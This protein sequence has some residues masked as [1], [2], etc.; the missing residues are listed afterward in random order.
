[1]ED[2]ED[3]DETPIEELPGI[4]GHQWEDYDFWVLDPCLSAIAELDMQKLQEAQETAE[5]F[6][7]EVQTSEGLKKIE[8][9][10]YDRIFP[11]FGE[12][13][14]ISVVLD[15]PP[16]QGP[17]TAGSGYLFFLADGSTTDDVKRDVDSFCT[18]LKQKVTELLAAS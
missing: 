16:N 18:A 17:G 2:D 10:Q 11:V 12:L 1:M 8:I 15:R 9:G 3:V 14:S 6:W 7:L 5:G 13:P 4:L